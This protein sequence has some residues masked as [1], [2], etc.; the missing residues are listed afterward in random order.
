MILSRFL[1][2]LPQDCYNSVVARRPQS[3]QEAARFVL[4]FEEDRTFSGR[5]RWRSNGSQQASQHYY[6]KREQGSGSGGGS[7]G[8]SSNNGNASNSS[9]SGPSTSQNQG[10][11]NNQAGGGKG[12]KHDKQSQGGRRPVTCYGCGEVGHIKPNCPNKVRRV[13][14]QESG[15]VMSVNGW[16]AGVEA[17]GL[18]VDTGA[19]RTV[20]R[21]DFVPEEAPA[22]GKEIQCD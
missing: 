19:D 14:P 3:G 11:S 6:N 15:S 16:L 12:G 17:K 9:G 21:T 13:K 8:G 1:S 5:Q 18:R 10:T 7:G 20:V 2:L 4:E 22:K